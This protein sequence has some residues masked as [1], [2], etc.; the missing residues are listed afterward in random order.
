MALVSNTDTQKSTNQEA[1]I[2]AA[3]TTLLKGP[4]WWTLKNKATL[5]AVALSTL[6]VLVVGAIAVGISGKQLAKS[7]VEQQAQLASALDFQIQDLRRQPSAGPETASASEPEDLTISQLSGL[8]N[9]RV[10]RLAPTEPGMATT[11]VTLISDSEAGMGAAMQKRFPEYA[12]LRDSDTLVTFESVSTQDEQPYLVTYSPVSELGEPGAQAGLL[13]YQPMATAFAARQ[14]IIL[15]ILCG[16]VATVL[17]VSV[18]AAYFSNLA[19]RPIVDASEAVAKLGHGKFDT[20]LNIVG[21][22]ELSILGLNI[23]I[24]ADQ[25][26]DQLVYIEE[27]AQRQGLFQAQ[28]AIAQQQ[29]QQRDAL[30]QQLKSLSDQVQQIARGN[31]HLRA[32]TTA[33]ATAADDIRQL[34]ASIDTVVE[35]LQG[36]TSQ[37]AQVSK[38]VRAVLRGQSARKLSSS[39]RA[40]VE[41]IKRSL[42]NAKAI[43]QVLETAATRFSQRTDSA[44]ITLPGYSTVT[45]VGRALEKQRSDTT[46][47]ARNISELGEDSQQIARVVGMINEI[48]LKINLLSINASSGTDADR[49]SAQA[50]TKDRETA[51]D[52]NQLTEQSLKVSQEVERLARHIQ[53]N[54]YTIA[55]NLDKQTD[56]LT[57]QQHKLSQTATLLSDGNSDDSDSTNAVQKQFLSQA[58]ASAQTL[59]NHLQ[60][61][62]TSANETAASTGEVE[63]ALAQIEASWQQME[64]TIARFQQP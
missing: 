23:N 45:E 5:L 53:A 1:D 46:K 11:Q 29:Q 57:K 27:S 64:E 19:T 30:I 51:D 48:A 61:L 52:I 3:P 9:Q 4:S 49:S 13:V 16:T 32:Q 2:Q 18:L 40:Q 47:I 15:A 62:S 39:A 20:R 21:S 38:P 35:Q 63:Q 8:I 37:I 36:V 25:L 58:A 43:T 12:A 44:S 6:P 33:D 17:L 34:A 31:I 41:S 42:A 54:A 60:Q 7:V 59:V 24:M 22:D 50:Q 14:S 10:A 26:E 56:H 55:G 28:V